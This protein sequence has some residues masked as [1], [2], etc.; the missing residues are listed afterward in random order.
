MPFRPMKILIVDDSPN[1]LASLKERM[2]ADAAFDEIKTTSSLSEAVSALSTF[3]PDAVIAGARLLGDGLPPRMKE[4]SVPV[5]VLLRAGDDAEI[6]RRGAADCVRLP[7][8]DASHKS[9]QAFCSEACVKVKIA[10]AAHVPAVNVHLPRAKSPPPEAKSNHVILIGA[11]TGGT[12]ATAEIFKHLSGGLP[13]IVV[14]QHMPSGFTKMYAQR[15]D[16]ISD[17]RVSEARDG[18]R[19]ERGK[20]LVAPGGMHLM[21]N[22]DAGGYYVQCVQ[23]ERV[24]G[25]CPSVGVLFDSAAKA[26]GPEAIGVLL[27][28]MGRDGA[29]G[30]LHMRKAGAYTIGQDRATSVVYGMPM[31]AFEIGAVIKQAPLDQIADLI[32]MHLK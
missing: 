19:V 4:K 11:S 21:L 17:I 28:G 26:A 1:L 24:N 7:E 6:C 20:A 25:H 16:G 23:G 10:A 14:V 15:L 9:W 3:E 8:E 18:D 30:L 32:V 29:E 13:G 2:S 12:D 5:V 27:T 22:K 31:V